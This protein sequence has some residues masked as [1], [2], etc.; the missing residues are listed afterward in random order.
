MSAPRSSFASRERLWPWY[1]ATLNDPVVVRASIS[2]RHWY[3]ATVGQTTKDGLSDRRSSS[4]AIV[5]IVFPM[6]AVGSD[7]PIWRRSNERECESVGEGGQRACGA[8]AEQ[9]MPKCRGGGTVSPSMCKRPLGSS[10]GIEMTRGA[11]TKQTMPQEQ[12]PRGRNHK[13]SI[14]FSSGAINHG[15]STILRR[16]VI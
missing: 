14:C 9:T 4:S 13:P 8:E 3:S 2:A 6:P 1:V 11:E 5:C 7:S 15:R 10:G 12:A 16:G